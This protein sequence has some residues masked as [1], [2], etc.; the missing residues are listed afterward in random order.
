[1]TSAN[2][3][4]YLSS[5]KWPVVGAFGAMAAFALIALLGSHYIRFLQKRYMGQYIREDGPASHQSKAG[6]PTLGGVLIFVGAAI[7]LGVAILLNPA[8]MLTHPVWI[9]VLAAL[10]FGIL[11]FSDDY[12]KIAKKKN[13]G[14]SGYSKLAVQ[15]G[16][17]LAVGLYLMFYQE[18]SSLNVFYQTPFELGLLY[19]IFVAL[20][21]TATSNAVNITDGLDGLAA[22]TTI[23]A[24]LAV[25]I[26]LSTTGYPELA[27]LSLVLLG[28]CAGF[29][30]FNRYPARIFMGD[31][32]SLALGGLLGT[33][34]ALG[35]AELWLPLVGIVY[36]VECLSV[37]L[38]VISFKSTG[39]R[40]FKMAPIH[41]HFELLGMHETQ[42]VMSFCG[43]QFL[44][45]LLGLY[46]NQQ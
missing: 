20:V 36:V 23:I 5:G 6:T 31:T 42:V 22:W 25:S 12:L 35:D 8:M 26:V 40:I 24:L 32:G 19:P 33:M 46:L 37:I 14:L 18:R 10:L 17:G 43:L 3:M 9:S 29:L 4:A 34:M 21:I 15:V 1:M 28:G 7:G 41:H 16:F 13:K 44:G 27:V 39:K 45:C 2:W 38:Q 30:L 11:G